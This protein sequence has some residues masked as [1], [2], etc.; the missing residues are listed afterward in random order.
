MWIISCIREDGGS[1]KRYTTE[2][3]H[4]KQEIGHSNYEQVL[5]K[6]YFLQRVIY[7]VV[8]RPILNHLLRIRGFDVFYLFFMSCDDGL[9]VGY[10]LNCKE[11]RH[12][13][14]AKNQY[15]QGLWCGHCKD[16][17]EVVDIHKGLGMVTCLWLY[18]MKCCGTALPIVKS[19]H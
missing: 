6:V 14:L 16:E 19:N 12:I 11:G 1:C 5:S 18:E 8:A 17:S 15:N 10:P 4:S 2:P 9:V 13:L 3:M 7:K